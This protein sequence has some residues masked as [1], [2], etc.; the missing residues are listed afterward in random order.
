MEPSHA[1]LTFDASGNLYGV[2]FKLWLRQQGYGLRIAPF[3]GS[4]NFSTILSNRKP[5]LGGPQGALVLDGAGNLYGAAQYD[6]ANNVG[7]VFKLTQMSGSWVYTDIHDFRGQVDGWLFDG[8]VLDS[9]G[10]IYGTA[11]H[12]GIHGYGNVFEIT[13]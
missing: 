2:H 7:S 6:G 3:G 11:F 9:K 10:N 1:G 4:W 13:P 8:L 12:G 5:F